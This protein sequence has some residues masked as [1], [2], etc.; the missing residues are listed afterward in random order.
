MLGFPF[1]C[2]QVRPELCVRREENSKAGKD[3][4]GKQQPTAVM[5]AM[6]MVVERRK[7]MKKVKP[8]VRFH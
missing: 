6:L 8:V 3:G 1:R 5:M 2:G 7:T 4:R